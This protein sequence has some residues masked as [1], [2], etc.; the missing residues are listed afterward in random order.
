[1]SREARRKFKLSGAIRPRRQPAVAAALKVPIDA[2]VGVLRRFEQN[3]V[4]S[5]DRTAVGTNDAPAHAAALLQFKIVRVTAGLGKRLRS[6]WN[7]ARSLDEH[8]GFSAG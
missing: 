4:C 5:N 2:Q 8:G 1:M 6:G 7:I 3:Q